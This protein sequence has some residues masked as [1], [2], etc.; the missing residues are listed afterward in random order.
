MKS[1]RETEVIFSVS[2]DAGYNISSCQT[3]LFT[4]MHSELVCELESDPETCKSPIN[5]DGL[6]KK[7]P[8]LELVISLQR[9]NM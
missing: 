6:K 5:R 9:F 4:V 1:I 7:N 2:Q 3:I 8:P